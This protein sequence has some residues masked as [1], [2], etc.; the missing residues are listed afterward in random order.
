MGE[1]NEG[2]TPVSAHKKQ[3]C[4]CISGEARGVSLVPS[5]AYGINIEDPAGR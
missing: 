5:R 4:Y 2:F 3:V 1:K